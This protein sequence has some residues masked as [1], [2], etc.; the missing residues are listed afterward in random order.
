MPGDSARPRGQSP[1]LSQARKR[2]P[3]SV[4]PQRHERQR[5]GR[6]HRDHRG[7]QAARRRP[8]WRAKR[9]GRDT[10]GQR[11]RRSTPS[12]CASAACKPKASATARMT[13]RK[14]SK[15]A[16]R[17]QRHGQPV[18]LQ[19]P[20]SLE[21]LRRRRSS[22]IGQRWPAPARSKRFLQDGKGRPSPSRFTPAAARID[23]NHG[24]VERTL[25]RADSTGLPGRGRRME[26]RPPPSG[27]T[28][29]ARGRPRPEPRSWQR[30]RAV[31]RLGHG[32]RDKRVL[33]RRRALQGSRWP[34]VPGTASG[35]A[36]RR[37]AA[38]AAKKPA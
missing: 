14:T 1:P 13:R 21:D 2:W 27:L 15:L 38:V 10:G 4:Q 7:H 23:R 16:N 12:L 36:R 25:G 19:N 6:L 22:M 3:P 35:I 31:E 29:P 34:A 30:G 33:N 17:R 28:Q 20:R 18:G 26:K 32:Q 24:L 37:A 11:G 8:S 5:P 9:I